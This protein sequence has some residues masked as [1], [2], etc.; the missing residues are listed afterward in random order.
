[1][2]IHSDIG[3]LLYDYLQNELAPEERKQVEDHLARCSLCRDEMNHLENVIT[4]LPVSVHPGDELPAEYWK[5]FFPAVERRLQLEERRKRF[6]PFSIELAIHM[7]TFGRRYI[8]VLGSALACVIFSIVVWKSTPTPPS[9]EEQSPIV[10]SPVQAEPASYRM[11]DYFQKSKI[12]LV[13]LA[14]MRTD[15]SQ[16]IDLSA[17]QKTSRELIYEARYLRHQPLDSRSA[18]LIDDLQK[19]HIELANMKEHDDAPNIEI[20]RTGIHRKNLLFKT[21]MAENLFDSSAVSQVHQF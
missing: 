11:H 17:E 5:N 15:E 4:A 21:R 20:L 14:N 6:Q 12:L 8:A 16:D 13:G 10:E 1:M 2:N 3:L 9:E 19:I 18:K 7:L